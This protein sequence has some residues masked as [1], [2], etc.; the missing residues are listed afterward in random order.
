M[1]ELIIL[2]KKETILKKIDKKYSPYY[3]DLYTQ[4][5]LGSDFQAEI[6]KSIT[7]LK[8]SRENINNLIDKEKKVIDFLVQCKEWT[9]K[10][11]KIMFYKQDDL[12]TYNTLIG[13]VAG[14]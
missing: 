7:E 6:E 12:N 3:R 10:E 5:M 13:E 11:T 4:Y 14:E 9:M 8:L 2:T 1:E